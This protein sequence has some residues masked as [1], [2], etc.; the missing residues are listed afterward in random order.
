MNRDASRRLRREEVTRLIEE[1]SELV[2]GQRIGKV[3]D[4]PGGNLRIVLGSGSNRKH[5]LISLHPETSRMILWS[6]P[7]SASPAPGE[8]ATALREL[9]SGARIEKVDQPGEDRVMR[10]TLS[11]GGKSAPTRELIVELFGR[12]GRL[13]VIEGESRRVLLVTGRGGVGRGDPYELPQR[14]RAPDESGPAAT[15]PFDPIDAIPI[16]QRGGEA[17]M[18]RWLFPRLEQQEHQY[19]LQ[20]LLRTEQQQLNRALKLLRRRTRKLDQDLEAGALWQHWLRIGELLKG[21]I[22]RLS[23]GMKSIEVQDWYQDGAPL[24]EIPLEE[25][26]TPLQ[27]IERCFRRSRKGKRSLEVLGERRAEALIAI[28][29]LEPAVAAIESLQQQESLDQESVDQCCKEA[30]ELGRRYGKKRQQ[31]RPQSKGP[32]K[33]PEAP[34]FRIFRSREGLEILAGR[35][36]RENDELSIRTARG[37]DLFFHIAN[38]PGAHVILR[39]D[40][41]RVAAPESIEDAAYVAAFLS[42]WRGP[43]AATVHWTEAKNVRKPKGLPPGK[44]LIQREREYRITPREDGLL[45]V[46][47]LDPDL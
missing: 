22:P 8:L 12:Q 23:R 35:S 38:R 43:G 2:V 30:R 9:L 21:N 39:I 16:D 28:S 42:G 17:P 40:R 24:V 11:R 34:R 36:A 46:T 14:A 5:L 27:N 41:G 26:R 1:L 31:P 4:A 44:V 29:E 15:L 47:V 25:D 7:P 33:S 32:N 13:V 20:A 10:L 3:F 37:N 45:S 18:H 19:R 6:D